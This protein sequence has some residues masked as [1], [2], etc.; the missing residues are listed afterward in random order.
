MFVPPAPVRRA[1][2]FP[3]LFVCAAASVALLAAAVIVTAPVSLCLRGRWRAVRLCCYCVIYLGLEIAALASAFTLWIRSGPALRRDAARYQEQNFRLIQTLL[4]RLYRAA[5]WLLWLRVEPVPG[6]QEGPR[7][8]PPGPV[9]VLARHAG[10]GDSFLLV[11]ALLAYA[12]LRPLLVLKHTLA[13][14]PCIDVL[15]HRVPHSFIRPGEETGRSAARIGALAARLGE[16]DALVVFPEG[17]NF[18]PGRR[19]RAIRRLRWRGHHQRARQASQLGNVLPPRPAGALAAMDAA[20]RADLVVVAH[21]GLEHLDSAAA[22]WRL[23]PLG[24]PVRVTWWRVPP[25][26]V[27]AGDGA[28]TDWLYTQWARMDAWIGEHAARPGPEPAG[29]AAP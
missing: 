10:P 20:P 25:A 27:P 1:V 28:R 16:R 26:G 21:T 23:L 12:G 15:M 19:R 9:I 13:L 8:R 7:Q 2:T 3:A 24:H 29:R 14:D 6:Q 17:G 5:R 22:L 18:T 11:Y 4:G